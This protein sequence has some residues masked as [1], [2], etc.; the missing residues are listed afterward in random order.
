MKIIGDE[1]AAEEEYTGGDIDA[2]KLVA[3]AYARLMESEK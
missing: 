3:D 1:L 2:D